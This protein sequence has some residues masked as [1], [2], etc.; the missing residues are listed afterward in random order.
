MVNTQ[1]AVAASLHICEVIECKT[2]CKQ[3][4]L[5]GGVCGGCF[6][7]PVA[8]FLYKQTR[9]V[10]YTNRLNMAAAI[11]RMKNFTTRC[12]WKGGW[13]HRHASNLQSHRDHLSFKNDRASGSKSIDSEPVEGK[14]TGFKY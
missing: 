5:F 6:D 1:E 14:L 10:N 3:I 12:N 8:R 13:C 4:K 2:Q 11:Q 7:G 9:H